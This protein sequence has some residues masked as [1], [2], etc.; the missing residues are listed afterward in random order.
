MKEVRE[1]SQAEV[2]AYVQS[3][4]RK[5]NIELVLSGGAVVAIYNKKYVSMDI[6][7]VIMY[8]AKKKEI[9]NA[10]EEISFSQ[11]GGHYRHNE[12]MYFVEF[13]PGPL[14]VGEESVNKVDEVQLITGMLKLLS[15]T[16]SIKDRLSAYY[17]WGDRQCLSQAVLISQA[18]QIDIHEVERWSEAEGMLKEFHRL[19]SQFG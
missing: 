15:P 13:L 8:T 11:T 3:H 10:M 19:K 16:D 5:K 4:F 18:K 17:H 6:D 1:M 9:I 14:T 2:A 12:S 7:L